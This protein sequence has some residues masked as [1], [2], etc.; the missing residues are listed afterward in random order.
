M[1]KALL[2]LFIAIILSSSAFPQQTQSDSLTAIITDLAIQSKVKALIAGVWQGNKE[3]ALVTYGESMTGVPVQRNMH[4]RI[5]GVTETFQGTL[6]MML[7]D[8]GKINLDDKISKWLPD[9]LA[10]DSVT[11][12]M[13]IKNTG[14]Y[15][16]YVYNDSFVD[17][18]LKEPFRE[19]TDEEIIS[20]SL[21]DG[22]LNFRPGTDQKYS[23]TEFTIL[24]DVMEKATGKTMKELYEENIFKPLGLM[25]TGYMSS[26]ELPFPVLHAFTSDR[27]VY[28]DATYWNPSWTGESGALYSNIEDLG[29]WGPIFGKGKLLSE[30]SLKILMSPYGD[31]G[32][33][34]FYFA[35]GFGV[36]NGWCMQNPSFNGFSGAFGYQPDGDYTVIIYGTMAEDTE[37]GNQSFNILKELSK[38]L[39]PDKP[40]N[41]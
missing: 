18:V 39:T 30:E 8:Q 35:S 40:I 41:F 31:L 19:I 2:S 38:F 3:L 25:N 37:P 21:G 4:F 24:G 5:G 16:D 23:H 17:L 34:G 36:V 1:G 7:V 12:G 22:Q 26:P 29:K 15:K 10:G 27:G 28:E 33:P 13:L 14:G 20:Y 32:K 9:I 6:L 11:V